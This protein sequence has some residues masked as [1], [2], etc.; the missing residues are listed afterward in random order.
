MDDVTR[1]QSAPL[2]GQKTVS[3]FE[4]LLFIV[5]G[6]LVLDTVATGAAI[7]VEGLT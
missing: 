7:G 1:S 3:M 6:I 5:S 2:G 4:M